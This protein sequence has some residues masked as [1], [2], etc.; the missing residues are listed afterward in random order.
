VR[1]RL[2]E[3]DPLVRLTDGESQRENE[4]E[5]DD[6]RGARNRLWGWSK[7]HSKPLLLL[8]LGGAVAVGTRIRETSRGAAAFEAAA[9]AARVAAQA[10]ADAVA[11]SEERVAGEV[12]ALG[13][14]YNMA[15]MDQTVSQAFR[16]H[17]DWSPEELAGLR[18]RA[19]RRWRRR[20]S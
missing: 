13:R 20:W 6:D 1:L 15:A 17:Q 11:A 14:E 10:A 4:S 7:E 5:R 8:T 12:Q 19:R 18:D 3:R 9:V 16:R 2:E